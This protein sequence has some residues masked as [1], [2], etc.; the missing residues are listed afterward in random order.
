MGPY[1]G[2]PTHDDNGDNENDHDIMMIT[3]A[4][5]E[6]E[7]EDN[8]DNDSNGD[9]GG[10]KKGPEGTPPYFGKRYSQK[11]EK[12]EGQAKNTPTPYPLVQGLNSPLGD[13]LNS[14]CRQYLCMV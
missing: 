11:E 3:T 1:D 4:N 10:S 7:D 2:I 12:P 8:N 9:S 13:F 6:V 5:D 14:T